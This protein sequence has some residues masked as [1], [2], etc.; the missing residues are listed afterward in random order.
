MDERAPAPLGGI[1]LAGGQSRRMGT[2]KALLRLE[3][4]G[5]TLIELVL[6]RLDAVAAE[7]IIIT[8]TPEIY[9]HL[10]RRMTGD[11]YPG[12][13]AL[14]GIQAGLAASVHEHNLVVACDMPFLHPGLLAYL[15]DHRR[16]YD[17]LLP[18]LH[19]GG[20]EPLHAVYSRACLAPMTA[21]LAAGGGRIIAYFPQLRVAYVD[22][23]ILRRFDPALRSLSNLNTPE[24]LAAARRRHEHEKRA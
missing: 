4:A 24:E 2:P 5:P 21:Q 14:A 3:P 23:P 6:A 16:D 10:G 20:L 12:L 17:V 7:V 11:Q 1:V 22:E 18:R 13:G 15:R 8:N 9:A 19:D